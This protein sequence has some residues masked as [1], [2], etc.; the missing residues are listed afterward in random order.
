MSD[1]AVKIDP[2]EKPWTLD[3]ALSLFKAYEDRGWEA[4]QQMVSIVV[5]L[6]PIIFGLIAYSVKSYCDPPSGSASASPAS[7]AALVL[8]IFLSGMIWG[9]LKRADNI[10]KK[11]EKVIE[12]P[13]T[14]ALLPSSVYEIVSYKDEK[15]KKQEQEKK[16]GPVDQEQDTKSGHRD[17]QKLKRE[18]GP[19][20]YLSLGLAHIAPVYILFVYVAFLIL[21]LTS[22]FLWLSP[23]R[24]AAM[25][26]GSTGS[27]M[28]LQQ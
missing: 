25:L 18:S 28:N 6:T 26:C 27:W 13:A 15:E 14:K 21:G 16:C 2:P 11:A 4:K 7:A 3:E 23:Q 17:R 8:S 22:F 1:P 9:A 19:G 12:D 10:Y 5:W 20:Y 24:A